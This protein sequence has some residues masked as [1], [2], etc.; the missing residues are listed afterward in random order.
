MEPTSTFID[1]L[2]TAHKQL[3]AEASLTA[4]DATAMATFLG[5]E[6]PNRNRAQRRVHMQVRELYLQQ[7]GATAGPR[8]ARAWIPWRAL[9]AW[10]IKNRV[11]IF[12]IV[13][14]VLPLII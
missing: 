14:M 8:R 6:H 2:R 4:E 10:I 1:A 12:R 3:V 5:S 9:I 7:T 11:L 13:I